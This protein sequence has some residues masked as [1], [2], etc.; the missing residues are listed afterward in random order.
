[1][2]FQ[3]FVIDMVWAYQSFPLI[4]NMYFLMANAA[5]VETF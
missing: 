3:L 5:I 2:L 4:A 1:M